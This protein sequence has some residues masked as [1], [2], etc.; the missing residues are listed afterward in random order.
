[1]WVPGTLVAI[2]RNVPRTCSGASGF[3]SKVSSWL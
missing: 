3:M 1:M 2:G